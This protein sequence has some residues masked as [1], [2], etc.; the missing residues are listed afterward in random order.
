[1]K[2]VVFGATG[3]TGI[4]FVQQA[5]DAGHEVV[6]F[7]R[8][9][10]KMPIVHDNLSLIKGD[11]MQAEDVAQAIAPDADAVVSVLAP[12]KNSPPDMLP[13]AAQNIISA[14]KGAGIE[15]LVYMTGAGVRVE[16]D[17]P[18]LMD[19]V[20]RF[21]L[22]TISGDVLKQSEEA[23]EK[24]RNSPLNWTVVRAPMLTDGDH[25]GDYRVGWVGVNT[26]PRLLRADAA[27]FILSLVEER[28][29]LHE[30]P[31]VSN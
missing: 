12:T 5:L 25:T 17:E 14:M 21:A 30:A 15:R 9:P 22:K 7:V 1:M 8:T 10:S 28:E 24:V 13:R 29:H 20:I 23:V 11:A 3:R 2:I 19:N 27:D 31:V 4:P 26:G 16:Q 6:G 18:G